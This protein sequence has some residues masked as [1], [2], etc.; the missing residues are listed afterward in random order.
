MKQ[1]LKLKVFRVS[2]NLNQE[3]MAKRCKVNR[4]SY[5]QIEQGKTRGS[6]EFWLNLKSEFKLSS[7]RIW[8][9]QYEGKE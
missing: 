6:E 1:R 8:E 7:D 9:M 5:S 3:E 4:G 2:L